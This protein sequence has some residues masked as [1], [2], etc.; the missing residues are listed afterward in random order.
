[1]SVVG[2]PKGSIFV[3]EAQKRIYIDNS[4][5]TAF[6]KCKELARLNN[7]LGWKLADRT[8]PS[9][10]A[11]DFGHAF[12]AAVAAYYDHAAGGFYDEDFRWQRYT[13]NFK[14]SAVR[15]A[16]KA[17]L[18]DLKE[19]GSKLKLQIEEDHRSIERGVA[20]VEAY[21]ERWKN[22]PYENILR[23]NGAPLTEIYFEIP[24]AQYQE[25]T[26]Y[27]CGTIDRIMM[28]IL[29]RRPRLFETKTTT[30]GLSAYSQERK[31]NQQIDGYF[32]IAWAFMA[33]DF[34][35]LPEIRD[36][37]W[38]CIFVSK[39]SPDTAKS[40]KQR[41]WMYGIDISEDFGRYETSRSKTD[42]IEFLTD[43][44]ADA[45]EFAKWLLSDTERWPRAKHSTTC[46]LFGGCQFR[47]FC[48]TNAAPEILTTWFEVKQWN[49]RKKL[50]EIQ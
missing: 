45:V 6:Q 44:E 40:L 46:H 24:V 25:W 10:D 11:I 3:D 36:C 1:M 23:P 31:P 4:T 41:F 42:I 13:E 50:R 34:P 33:A 22:E 16:Q 21:V 48:S 29:T 30:R 2:M 12:H 15:T 19:Q 14:P 18:R 32:K 37:V 43:V 20:L 49:P 47:N 27:Y 17:F 35:E 28:H 5:R 38:D 7:V 9:S 39:R 26:I 8:G